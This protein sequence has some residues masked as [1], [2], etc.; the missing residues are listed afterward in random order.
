MEYWH[1]R[2]TEFFSCFF[3]ITHSHAWVE[4]W[5]EIHV[6]ATSLIY[7]KTTKKVSKPF[8]WV[9]IRCH[10]LSRFNAKALLL[11]ISGSR[12]SNP[13][14]N[15]QDASYRADPVQGPPCQQCRAGACAG[16][17]HRLCFLRYVCAGVQTL[18]KLLEEEISEVGQGILSF[19]LGI[20][21]RSNKGLTDS[22]TVIYWTFP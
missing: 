3:I 12:R 10:S 9:T 21:W 7:K 2:S 4:Q 1:F 17:Q 18:Q 5:V 11:L 20:L 22:L 19:N 8:N 16:L 14:S 6:M 13:S 15:I